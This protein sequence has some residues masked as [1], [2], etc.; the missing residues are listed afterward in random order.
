MEYNV[1]DSLCSK[2]VWLSCHSTYEIG[3]R[4]KQIGFPCK[5][6]EL[7][8]LLDFCYRKRIPCFVFGL[9]A[10]ILFPDYPLQNCLYIS[11][12][13]YSW[14]EY[15]DNQLFISAGVPL[16]FLALIGLLVGTEKFSFTYLLPGTVGGG[17][18][19]NARCL[20][21]EI[22]TLVEKIHYFD[23]ED[24]S[25]KNR[26]VHTLLGKEGRFAYKYSI[27]QEKPW[28]ISGITINVPGLAQSL[29]KELS[30]LL[31]ATNA[32]TNMSSLQ[33]FYTYFSQKA[34]CLARGELPTSLQKIEK[35]RRE[36]SH[37]R[38][39][40]CG[41]FF[42]N[43][44]EFGTPTGKL[45]D[46]LKLKGTLLGGAMISPFH[47]NFIINFNGAKASQVK[48]LMALIVKKISGTYGFRPEPEVTICK[49]QQ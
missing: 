14:L 1:F 30:L 25:G 35:M 19:M 43:N 46:R 42:K 22:G 8:F 21:K 3:G 5:E 31:E 29:I 4:V 33:S 36:N 48:S 49:G 11:L 27:F 38:F 17:V 20:D 12:K 13:N 34:N 28:I 7:A 16:S 6:A 15:K 23:L 39:P 24:S 41:S 40:S 9:G 10:N 45:V 44:Y 47:G 18:Y 2:N 37:F 26:A 32:V